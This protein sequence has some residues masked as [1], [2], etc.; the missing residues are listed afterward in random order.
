MGRK[1]M[2][3]YKKGDWI[4]VLIGST[5]YAGT[6]LEIVKAVEVSRLHARIR[7]QD[8]NVILAES[9]CIVPDSYWRSYA[10]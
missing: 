6:F 10:P 8:G 3:E 5:W 9:R 1:V 4:W 2:D 7:L